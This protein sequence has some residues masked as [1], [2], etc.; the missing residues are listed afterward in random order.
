MDKMECSNQVK[1]YREWF[2]RLQ[3]PRE[4]LCNAS[5]LE[6]LDLKTKGLQGCP[7]K[8]GQLIVTK[9]IVHTS[10]VEM[11]TLSGL[12]TAS[13]TSSLHDPNHKIS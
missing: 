8:F 10:R 13:S 3:C 5:Q 2:W 7:E 12:N 4:E 9:R 1:V 11:V 6:R